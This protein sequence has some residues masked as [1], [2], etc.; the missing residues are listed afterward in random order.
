[1]GCARAAARAWRTN[2]AR[3]AWLSTRPRAGI[4]QALV[5]PVNRLSGYRF[6]L[7]CREVASE[8]RLL[9]NIA[10]Q[11]EQLAGFP[12]RCFPFLLL[13]VPYTYLNLDEAAFGCYSLRA[14]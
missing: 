10:N 11:Q 5:E 2:W 14:G 6:T 13:C 4:R 9:R 12:Q 1:M 7:R 8:C 3:L